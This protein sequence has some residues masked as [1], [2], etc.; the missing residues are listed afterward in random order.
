VKEC[1]KRNSHSFTFVV[2]L[3]HTK[4]CNK[5]LIGI[6]TNVNNHNKAQKYR[7]LEA[8]EL[9]SVVLTVFPQNSLSS[10]TNKP[11]PCVDTLKTTRTQN[12]TGMLNKDDTTEKL[13]LTRTIT[14]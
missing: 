4:T 13:R 12:Q 10:G 11:F 9:F 5:I 1:D 3:L 7:N 8:S 6:S 2:T 14:V